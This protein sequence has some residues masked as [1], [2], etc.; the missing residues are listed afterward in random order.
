MLDYIL[1]LI[2]PT[3]CG[4][5]DKIC[6]EALCKKC[7]L[8]LKKYEI[9]LIRKNRNMYFTESMHIFRYESIIR[10]KIID[11][12]FNNKAYLYK[13][14]SEIILKNE[15]VCGLLKKYDIIIP[16]PIHKKRKLERG[17]NQT[18]LIAKTI[19]N[20]THIKLEKDLLIKQSNI[21][22][23]SSLNKN[24][25]KQNVKNAFVIKNTEKIENKKILIFDDIYTTGSTV[26][27]CSKI[28]RK[29][30]ATRIGILTISKD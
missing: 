2:Y 4:I 22:S 25:R 9:N 10:E 14:F 27:E 30:G 3:T 8:K 17:Y 12:K 20:Q 7:E 29:A 15:K 1:E 26:N 16:V 18:E 13:T 11:Y 6:K 24:D 21:V 28:L 23:Q 5:C 19:A